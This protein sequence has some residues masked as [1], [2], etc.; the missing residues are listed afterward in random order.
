MIQLLGPHYDLNPQPLG[1]EIPPGY[2][3]RVPTAENFENIP[4]A[5]EKKTVIQPSSKAAQSTVLVKVQ[6]CIRGKVMEGRDRQLVTWSPGTCKEEEGVK[7]KN[8]KR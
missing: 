8:R 6:L 5:V 3:T 4:M 1:S 2:R 7:K